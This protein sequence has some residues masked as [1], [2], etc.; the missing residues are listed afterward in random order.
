MNSKTEK[1]KNK[2]LQDKFQAILSQML[3]EED[4]K[5]CVDCDSKGQ[6]S[7]CIFPC[8]FPRIVWCKISANKLYFVAVHIRTSLG[9]MEFRNIS[10]HPMCRYSS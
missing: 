10:L 3:R 4:N 2:A 1:D 7:L 5:F 9:F 6:G 8:N